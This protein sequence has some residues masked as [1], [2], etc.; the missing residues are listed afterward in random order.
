MNITEANDFIKQILDACRDYR[1]EL[2]GKTNEVARLREELAEIK[3]TY[4]SIVNQPHF[5]ER[6][7]HCSCV[8]ALREE[9]AK[10]RDE[11]QKLKQ[12]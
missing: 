1:K 8:P 6:E 10:L 3:E 12:K 2:S 7:V 11:I 5:D 4:A 9:V